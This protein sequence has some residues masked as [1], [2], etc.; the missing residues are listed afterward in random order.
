MDTRAK[1][2]KVTI[3]AILRRKNGCRVSLTT[4]KVG[5][6][7]CKCTLEDLGIISSYKEKVETQPEN[8]LV[9]WFKTIIGW[10][11]I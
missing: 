9:F 2:K 6:L 5:S 3:S 1:I 4:H 11:K 8:F 7:G 10:F